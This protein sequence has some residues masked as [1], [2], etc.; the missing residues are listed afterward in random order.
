M[1]NLGLE[2]LVGKKIKS[3][4]TNDSNDLVVLKTDS[5]T[6]YLTWNG[7]CCAHC[8]LA[9]MSGSENLINAEILE[10]TDAEWADISRKEDYE[11]IE[12]MGTNMKTSKGH[13]SFETRV[14]HNGYYGGWITVNTKAPVDEYSCERGDDLT[15]LKPLVDF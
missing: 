8:F 6:I 12:S 15:K 11:V 7:D 1:E 13:V 9:N 3:A 4:D 10:V 2:Y 5:E 14:V